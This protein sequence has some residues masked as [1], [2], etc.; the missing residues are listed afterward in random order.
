MDI[1]AKKSM[2]VSLIAAT[3]DE[4][5]VEHL[6]SVAWAKE[7]EPVRSIVQLEGKAPPRPIGPLKRV[8]IHGHSYRSLRFA[9]IK[10]WGMNESGY[11][12]IHK[13]VRDGFDVNDLLEPRRDPE[14]KILPTDQSG[15]VNA[16]K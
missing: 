13:R 1:E 16:A 6:I 14:R 5:I 9:C 2:L 7:I 10:V 15:V 12:K 11:N 4:S 8:E 3:E